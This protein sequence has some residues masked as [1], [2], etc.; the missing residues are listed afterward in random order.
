MLSD[1]HHSDIPAPAEEHCIVNSA[2]ISRIHRWIERL[3]VQY[4]IP[5]NVQF[6]ADL[7]LEEVL[8]N[9]FLHGYK[10]AGG[11]ALVRFATSRDGRFVFI[12]E[13]KAPHFNPLDQQELPALNPNHEMRVGG[14]GLRLLRKFTDELAYERL[15]AG[16]RVRMVFAAA[17]DSL[18]STL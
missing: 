15:P 5:E 14:Q 13:D 12:V 11:V 16:N 10:Q 2:E 4:A 6:A 1:R 18:A 8:S 7:C 17:G 3:C 9:I